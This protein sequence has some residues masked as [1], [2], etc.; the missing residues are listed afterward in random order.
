MRPPREGEPLLSAELR[1]LLARSADK[2]DAAGEPDPEA[3][4]GLRGSGLLGAAVPVEHGGLGGGGGLV[5]RVVE[6]IASVNPSV[7]II[8][9]QHFAVSARIAE[10]GSAAQR[11]RWLPRLAGGGLLAASAW[12]ESGAG[13]AKRRL[14]SGGRRI[15]GGRWLLSGSKTFTTGAGVADL[16]LV[17]VQT[18]EPVATGDGYGAQGQTFFLVEAANPGLVPDLGLELAGMRGSA[19]GLV[20]LADC[21][22][23][24]ADRLGPEG[25]AVGI[26]AGV[27]ESGASLGAVSVGIARAALD[28][29]VGHAGAQGL[30]GLPAVRLRLAELATRL[31]AARAVV[32]VAGA[33]TSAEVGLMTLHSKLHATAAAEDV[34][35]EVARMLG[36]AGYREGARIGR[37]LGD[38]RG[39]GLMGPTN[40]LC[41]ELVA[42]TW[43]G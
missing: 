21:V 14:A 38:A 1:E 42:A 37:L 2:A 7:A 13:A 33:R 39:V 30:L 4:A 31:E 18:S 16:Y 27:R 15:D 17:L 26:I 32:T 20:A 34:C 8:A 36:S 43:N 12:S 3:L 19:T 35:L 41:R 29:A 24:D 23:P 22:V 11:E 9:F 28:L 25:G 10:H 5:N 40:D 6:D